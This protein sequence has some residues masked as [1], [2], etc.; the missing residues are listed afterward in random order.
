MGQEWKAGQTA[1][2]VETGFKPEKVY[3]DRSLTKIGSKLKG[4]AES[5]LEVIPSIEL[6]TVKTLPGSGTK[7]R[8]NTRS[9]GNSPGMSL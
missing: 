2:H 1:A 5:E 9:T 8:H 4:F 6:Q 7:R 3:K